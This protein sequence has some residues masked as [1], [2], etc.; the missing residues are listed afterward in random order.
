M[1]FECCARFRRIIAAVNRTL[2]ESGLMFGI[3]LV[4][5]QLAECRLIAMNA[6]LFA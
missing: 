1:E 5:T 3:G 4:S 2:L 6:A